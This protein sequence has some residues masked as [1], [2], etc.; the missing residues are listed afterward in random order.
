MKLDVSVSSPVSTSARAAQVSAMFDVPPTTQAALAWQA[1]FPYDA[2]P[3]N[4]GLVVGPSGSGKSTIL[5]HVFGAPAGLSWGAPSVLDD[6]PAGVSIQAIVDACSA[7]GF[8]TIPAWLRPFAVLSNGEKFRVDLA[9]RLLTLDGVVVVDEF[10]SVVDRQVARVGSHAVQKFIRRAGKQF[11]AASCHYD[12]IEWLQPDWVLDASTL[13]FTRRLLQRRP[14]IDAE[15]CRVSFD[16][17]RVFAPFHY[18]T[19]EL[20]KAARCFGMYVDG[21]P[22]AFAGIMHRPHPKV[23]DVMGVSR[24]VTLPDWQGLGLAM[25]LLDK[26][27]A[28]YRAIGKRLHMYPSHPGFVRTFDRSPTWAL[29][30]KPGVRSN[31]VGPNSSAPMGYRPCAVFSY[32]GPTMAPSDARALIE[33]P[34]RPLPAT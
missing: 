3:W 27:G 17:W 2:Q 26:L 8:N 29:E 19:A 23:D 9:R 25:I 11:V 20:H 16:H 31:R 22:V 13:S 30:K 34:A 32:Q 33:A 7:V 10:T 15:V 28:A 1:D 4:V 14:S 18:L 21:R 5:N 24:V 6:F 12:I